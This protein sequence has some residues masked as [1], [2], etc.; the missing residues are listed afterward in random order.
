[1]SQADYTSTI[2]QKWVDISADEYVARISDTC[3]LGNPLIATQHLLGGSK[4]IVDSDTEITGIHQVR[5]AHQRFMSAD[6]KAVAAKGHGHAVITH[7]Y[8]LVECQ[9]RLS[10]LS[11]A[12]HWNEYDFAGVFGTHHH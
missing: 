6:R 10:G 4:W 8:S 1:M 11:P 9:W 5:A 3:M 12:V 2:G 7:H